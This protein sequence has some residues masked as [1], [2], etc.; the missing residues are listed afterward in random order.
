MKELEIKRVL[1]QELLRESSVEVLASEFL[2]DFGRCRADLIC[3]KEGELYGYEIKSA[4]DKTARLENQLD[5]YFQLF[6][7][8]TVVCDYKHFQDVKK[9]ASHRTGIFFCGEDGIIKRRSPKKV[10]KQNA[11]VILDA[12][13]S[14]YLRRHFSVS[15]KSKFDLCE[16]IK[17]QFCK[18]DIKVGFVKYLA[19][20]MGPQTRLLRSEVGRVVTLDDFF[21]LGLSSAQIAQEA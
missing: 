3:V 9:T 10:L 14:D 6:D 15:A 13:P 17:R 8:V 2:F 11:L 12:M 21:S 1:V 18:Q 4:F 5:S 16:Q 7:Y 20:R 19:E